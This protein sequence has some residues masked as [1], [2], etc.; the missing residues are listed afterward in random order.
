MTARTATHSQAARPAEQDLAD[1]DRLVEMLERIRRGD[2]RGEY[3]PDAPSGSYYPQGFDPRSARA[4]F[5]I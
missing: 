2:Y 3:L 4:A 1:I 5:S